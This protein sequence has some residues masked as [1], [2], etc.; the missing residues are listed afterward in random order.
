MGLLF[1]A[2][3][4]CKNPKSNAVKTSDAKQVA[5]VSGQEYRSDLATSKIYWVG[6]SPKGGHNGFINL[7]SGNI[8]IDSDKISGGN[9]DIDMNSIYCE[10]LKDAEDKKD[11]ENHLKG[12]DF[13]EVSKFPKASFEIVK[14][15]KVEKEG[16]VNING[17]L[18]VKGITKNI[19]FEAM[20]QVSEGKM[21]LTSESFSIN[22]LE[23]EIKY[24][25]KS[26]F[27]D[28]KDRFIYDDL[29]IKLHLEF[30]IS[31]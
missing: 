26:F 30:V 20:P 16:Y 23:W 1:L 22:R 11:L 7:S 3:V 13:F 12:E 21:T 14:V 8:F 24:R 4:S 27:K 18:T 17:N 29:E 15:S 2:S 28:L 5:M 9:F 10:D 19:N 31:G 25:S 6:K